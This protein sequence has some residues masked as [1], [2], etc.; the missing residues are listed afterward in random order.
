[1]DLPFTLGQFLGV[2][3]AYN[4]ALFPAQFVAYALGL[5]ALALVFSPGSS[6]RAGRAIA[7]I[8]ALLWIWTGGVYHIL[9]FA[10]IDW[11]AYVFG[12][13]FILQGVLFLYSGTA[14]GALG[15]RFGADVSGLLGA[16][17]ILYALGIYPLL[18]IWLGHGYP[19]MPVFGLTPCP[20][21]VFTLG[22]LLLAHRPGRGR[23]V[24]GHLLLIP[25]V[26]SLVG[27]MAAVS[28]GMVE[29]YGLL[30]AGALTIVVI[31]ER[32]RNR[33]APASR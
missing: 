4:R 20:T 9:Y 28:L 30:A 25:F 31:L 15:F 32:R 12:A 17:F 26:W 7:A 1:M 13:L 3:A 6:P 27:A 23:L 22:M 14:R 2:F 5:A 29:D 21:T 33:P 18:N 11:L 16:L 10:R 24:P 8:L 19:R